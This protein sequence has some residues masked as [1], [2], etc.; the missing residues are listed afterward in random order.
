MNIWDKLY[1]EAKSKL[2]PRVISPF[3][4][5]GGVATTILT[6]KGNIYWSMY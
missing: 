3:I 2:N 6:D 1:D 4:K 5:A